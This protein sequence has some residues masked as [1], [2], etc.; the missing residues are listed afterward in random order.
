MP[1]P[2][3]RPVQ[4][5]QVSFQQEAN[6]LF[7]RASEL[8]SAASTRE[9]NAIAFD[10]EADTLSARARSLRNQ[11]QLVSF[12]TDRENILEIADELVERAQIDRSRASA[13]RT[14]ASELRADARNLRERANQLIRIGTGGRDGG[15]WRGPKRP[16]ASSEGVTL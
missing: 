12:T 10:T 3:P 2:K 7:A 5:Q 15:P 1:P 16:T 6:T 13:E 4:V 11:A 9:R 8:D 14:R